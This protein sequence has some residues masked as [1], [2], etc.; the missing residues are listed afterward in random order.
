MFRR[1]KTRNPG[2]PTPA[3][4]S[5]VLLR[6]P[7]S[8]GRCVPIP[9]GGLI[10]SRRM[11]YSPAR[12]LANLLSTAEGGS[13][14]EAGV[15]GAQPAGA[16][17][18]HV[19]SACLRLSLHLRAAGKQEPPE[20]SHPARPHPRSLGGPFLPPPSSTRQQRALPAG[21]PRGPVALLHGLLAWAR[22]PRNARVFV[23]LQ[24]ACVCGPVSVSFCVGSLFR[25]LACGPRTG[26]PPPQPQSPASPD[27]ESSLRGGGVRQARVPAPPRPHHSLTQSHLH[28]RSSFRP[29][30][31][32]EPVAPCRRLAGSQARSGLRTPSARP[33]GLGGAGR[34]G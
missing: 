20:V 18:D 3:Q 13:R 32:P 10:T 17:S 34:G 31:A 23:C 2:N 7:N 11:K 21:S 19:L 5:L 28:R 6:Y 1:R 25:L 29:A 22:P 4:Q 9:G 12:Y 16:R 24:Y 15:G 27:R 8:R 26:D 33:P 30:P 14:P